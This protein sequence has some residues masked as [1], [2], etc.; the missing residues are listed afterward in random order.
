VKNAVTLTNV[1]QLQGHKG[2]DFK[3]I[4]NDYNQF[5]IYAKY[6]NIM[7][8]LK[9]GVPRCAYKGIVSFRFNDNRIF[10]APSRPSLTYEK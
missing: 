2:K 10:L 9:K 5:M 3:Y 1:G 8:E 6:F 7:F 4:Y